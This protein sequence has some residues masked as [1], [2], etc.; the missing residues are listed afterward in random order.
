[1]NL[2]LDRYTDNPVI[3]AIVAWPPKKERIKTLRGCCPILRKPFIEIEY[4]NGRTESCKFPKGA[5]GQFWAEAVVI[6][7]TITD[8]EIISEFECP[9]PADKSELV[10]ELQIAVQEC[11]AESAEIFAGG[12]YKLFLDQYGKNYKGL[13]DEVQ[14]KIERAQQ[15]L[16]D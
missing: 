1:M 12:M 5:F 8:I 7:E 9:P 16:I 15:E 6:I 10:S 14:E 4:E 2:V 11:I 13:P 3:G